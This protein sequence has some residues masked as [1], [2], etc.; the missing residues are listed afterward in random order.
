MNTADEIIQALGMTPLRVE[1]GYFRETYR[2]IVKTE[3]TRQR[4]AGTSILYLMKGMDVSRW[5]RVRSDEIWMYHA[6]SPA[7]QIL[8]FPDGSW[9]ER[10]IG[11]DVLAGEMP[12]NLIPAWTWQAAVLLDRSEKSWGLFGAVVVPG[13]EYED[14]EEGVASELVKKYPEAE[15]RIR[16]VGLYV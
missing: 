10:V 1:G 3:A 7:L 13:F 5:H 8:L 14:F 9:C 6:G 4:R 11:P 2:S 16:E 12:Q 15:K